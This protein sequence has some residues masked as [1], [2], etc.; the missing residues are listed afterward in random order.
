MSNITP[1]LSKFLD[2]AID[3][4]ERGDKGIHCF[5]QA[6]PYI[7]AP[8]PHKKPTETTYKQKQGNVELKLVADS[9]IGLP[10]G[11]YSRLILAWLT[12]TAIRHK[13]RELSFE[14]ITRFAKQFGILPTGGNKGTLTALRDHAERVFTT[15]IHYRYNGQCSKWH[16][17]QRI[18]FFP[19]VKHE[20]WLKRN[21]VDEDGKIIPFKAND[22]RLE[23]TLSEEFYQLATNHAVPFKLETLILL[24]QSTFAMDIYLWL[25][26]S[27]QALKTEKLVSW[28][29]LKYQFGSGYQNDNK[30]RFAFKKCFKKA[31]KLI[32]V[33][34]P[35]ANITLLDEGLR[36]APSTPDIHERSS[37]EHA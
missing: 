4:Q 8:L 17:Y 9:D 12:T 26:Y 7:V 21:S 25:T 13:T 35:Q 30:G 16:L 31:L 37:G 36:L 23:L 15:S 27:F 22:A 28:A 20:L 3:L 10:Y 19:I 34:Y 18:N 24:R 33:A 6:S 32:E 2:Q 5:F 1:S 29:S 14:S 11:D